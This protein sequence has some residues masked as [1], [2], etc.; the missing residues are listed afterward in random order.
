MLFY[1]WHKYN[2]SCHA[3]IHCFSDINYIKFPYKEIRPCWMYLI[4]VIIYIIY[5][6]TLKSIRT[7]WFL[8]QIIVKRK[9]FHLMMYLSLQCYCMGGT[10]LCSKLIYGTTLLFEVIIHYSKKFIWKEIYIKK[11]SNYF[12]MKP[13]DNPQSN[14][15]CEVFYDWCA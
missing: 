7:K 6:S 2:F 8:N 14:I 11:S 13:C 15:I 12:L 9:Y 10:W 1:E 3:A 5:K 4:C